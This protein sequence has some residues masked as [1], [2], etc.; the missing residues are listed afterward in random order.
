[1]GRR[2]TLVVP[3]LALGGAERVVANMANHWAAGGDTVTVITLSAAT[4]DTYAL[5]PA[6]T[7]IALDLMRVSA[8]PIQALFNNLTRIGKLGDA[9]RSTRPDT[10]VA[11]TD[12]MNIVTLLACRSIADDVDTVISER[13]DPSRQPGGL[14]WTW[15]RAASRMSIRGLERWSYRPKPC[16][17]RWTP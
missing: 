4:T 13:I 10:V 6:V 17:G 5:D 1:M 16:A 9:I 3:S 12:R 7:R 8:G 15:S 11:F 2:L 14:G